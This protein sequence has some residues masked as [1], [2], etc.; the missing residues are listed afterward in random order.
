M[1]T[2]GS[3]PPRKAVLDAAAEILRR[4]DPALTDSEWAGLLDSGAGREIP[5]RSEPVRSLG[6]WQ[7]E[8]IQRTLPSGARLLDL[9]C[10]TGELLSRLMREK[11]ISGQGVELDADA[12]AECV[13]RSVPVLQMD[14]AGGLE[15]FSDG[16]FDYVLLEDTL[17]TLRDPV[18]VLKEM[19]RVGRNGI[20]SFPNFGHW[21][22]RLGLALNGRMP[23]T[24]RL[25]YRWY[26]TP[27]IH[28]FTLMDFLDWASEFGVRVVEGYAMADG[29]VR[30]LRPEDNLE[31][32]EVLLFLSNGSR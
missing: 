3:H 19:L 18:A 23:E 29:T 9:G 27:N 24:E 10:G 25:P 7:D 26:D 17:Q 15:E 14:A 21:R 6:R 1:K 12:V 20:V 5:P 16:H 11:K 28:L 2:E 31:A 8:V 30:E 22:V 4:M 32:E 13:A